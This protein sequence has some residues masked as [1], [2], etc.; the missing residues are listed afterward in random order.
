MAVEKFAMIVNGG[1]R[2]SDQFG[3]SNLKTQTEIA[4]HFPY[5]PSALGTFSF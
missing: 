2:K 4:A 3:I 1:D 5:E